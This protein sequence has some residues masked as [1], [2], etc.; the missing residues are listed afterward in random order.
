VQ[1][2]VERLP[3]KSAAPDSDQIPQRR[4]MSKGPIVLQNSKVAGRRISRENKRRKAI[5]DS[6]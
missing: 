4:D 1:L 2:Q 3:R 6:Y 5:A